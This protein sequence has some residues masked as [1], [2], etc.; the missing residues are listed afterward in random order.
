MRCEVC[1]GDSIVFYD[2]K[3]GVRIPCW[4]CVGG[5]TNCCDGICEQPEPDSNLIIE[6]NGT[7]R[8]A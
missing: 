2:P 7:A 5:Q 8:T 6:N 4:N 1:Q 3:R